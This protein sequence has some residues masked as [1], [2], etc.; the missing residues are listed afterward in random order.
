MFGPRFHLFT[1]FGFPI[2]IDL[3]WFIIAVLV[4]WSL[5]VGLFG[6]EELFPMLVDQPGTRWA[7]GI[8]GALGLFASIVLHE[9]GHA[10]MAESYGLP[11]RGITLFIFGG[12]AEMS[13]E[14]PSAKAE[15]MVA[16]AGP[17]VS[18]AIAA[19]TTGGW[20]IGRALEAPVSV[21]AVLG[22]LGLINAILVAFNMIPAFPLDGGRVL[23]S[24]LWAAKD[25]LRWATRI[26]SSIGSGFG[27]AL[28]V[29]AGLQLLTG[30]L[31]GAI[32][33][34]ILGMFLRGAAQMSY[35]QLL[36][37]RALEGEPVDR[38]M[39]REPVTVSPDDTIDHVVED[40]VY[41]HHYKFYPVTEDGEDHGR[42][43]GCLTLDRIKDVPR[44][45]WP[46]TRVHDVLEQCGG[47]NTIEV[48]RDAMDAMARMRESNRSRLMV[49]HGGRLV[50]VVAL[51]DLM[52]FLSMK[53]ELEER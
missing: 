32:W 6:S 10:K 30:N 42:L 15:F 39:S 31:V 52:D 43:V 33:W 8:I 28:M 12:V 14:P 36:I 7:M 37:R 47:T 5:A 46:S 19:V 13:Q 21:T 53:V 51:K 3:S 29:L 50:G 49:V 38:F 48:G 24:I 27:I 45:Q 4:T 17:I 1:L 2:Y 22:Y 41:R 16:V 40:F 44:D 9:L 34:F 25:N 18:I 35:Q 23:R 11:M 26:T 20:A